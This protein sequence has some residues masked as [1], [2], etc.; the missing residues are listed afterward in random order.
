MYL[1]LLTRWTHP[2]DFKLDVL[3][4]HS[5][6]CLNFCMHYLTTVKDER[7]DSGE[8]FS[9]GRAVTIEL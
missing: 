1:F 5:Y 8:L 2:G 7:R 3:F 6:Q 9:I 4:I